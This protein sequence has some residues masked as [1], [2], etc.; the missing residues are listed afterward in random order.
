MRLT[1]AVNLLS[2]ITLSSSLSTGG[3]NP[4]RRQPSQ[5]RSPS[6]RSADRATSSTSGRDYRTTDVF[7]E[8]DNSA[9]GESNGKKRVVVR[10]PLVD[11]ALL[12]FLAKQKKEQL[13]SIGAVPFNPENESNGVERQPASINNSTGN[14]AQ[15]DS[16]IDQ[17]QSLAQKQQS[18]RERENRIPSSRQQSGSFDQASDRDTDTDTNE[19]LQASS[20]IAPPADLALSPR[21]DDS[22]DPWL[23]QFNR[24][25]VAQILLTRGGDGVDEN[26]ANQAGESVERH[27]LA[28]TARRRVR[29]F[30][31]ARDTMWTGGVDAKETSFSEKDGPSSDRPN[32]EPD[33]GFND[34]LDVLIE[35]GLTAKDV[36]TILIH[37]P[38]IAVM[39]PQR[40]ENA[41][42]E[43]E[44]GGETIEETLQRALSDILCGTL[45][46]RRYDARKVLR[47]CPGLLTK[48]GSRSAQQVVATMVKLG[49]STSSIARDKNALPTLLSRP[50][51]ALFRLI[52]FLSSDAIR[53]PLNKIGPLIR[54]AECSQ[55]L[56]AVVPVPPLHHGSEHITTS[57][58]PSPTS[59]QDDDE[60]NS[61]I[62]QARF[63]P[64]FAGRT[65]EDRR[66]HLDETYD[67][68]SVTAWLLRNEIGTSDLGK[69]ISA[70]P[71]VLLLDAAEQVLPVAS[72]LMDELGIWEDDLAKV[73]QLYPTLLGIPVSKMEEVV[74]FLMSQGVEEDNLSSMFRSF[75]YLLTLSIEEDMIPVIDFLQSIGINNHG[76]FISRLP[77]ILGYSVEQELR[78]KWEVIRNIYTYT[79]FELSKFPAFF[80]YPLER[81]IKGRFEYLRDVKQ[82]PI[83][84]IAPDLVLRY[85]D[86]DFAVRVAG[87]TDTGFG[88]SEFLKER[89]QGVPRNSGK[90]N[91]RQRNKKAATKKQLLAP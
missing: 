24:N 43:G 81:V 31:K 72:Y 79:T 51:A 41:V 83:S 14:T 70:Y 42:E 75:P 30:L 49:V 58:L 44:L 66:N 69:V 73:L 78:P 45:K 27:V 2:L 89:R 34:V 90:N 10:P 47:N 17:Q 64:A 82:L 37:T 87:D 88:F 12:R 62:D 61:D 32:N 23:G 65:V 84:L 76:R 46:L 39:M 54:R 20:S 77:P 40:P 15:I 57:D 74:A 7:S 60:V 3:Q 53:M 21:A 36:A 8:V 52:A 86:K 6:F 38:H 71:D 85:G 19:A 80:S 26:L 33:Y 55:L 13:N 16:L 11:S 1:R 63:L 4:R 68:M 9:S 50:P 35:N 48:R 67:R 59:T 56:D 18:G 22:F 28:R 29:D 25:R 91:R 5:S